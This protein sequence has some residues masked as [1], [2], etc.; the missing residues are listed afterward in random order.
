LKSVLDIARELKSPHLLAG[1][2][3][4]SHPRQIVDVSKLRPKPRERVA[5]QGNQLPREVIGTLLELGYVDTHALGRT[6]EQFGA[7]LSTSHPA[8][9]VDFILVTPEL[10]PAVRSSVVYQPEMA[11]FASDHYP[12]VAE[13][14]I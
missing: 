1:D 12:V 3:N 4:S 8:M 2:F 13:I 14:E 6:P 5:A 9:R 10:Q 7:S 11:R